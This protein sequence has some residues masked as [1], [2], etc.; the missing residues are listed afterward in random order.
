MYVC[1]FFSSIQKGGKKKTCKFLVQIP[2]SQHHKRTKMKNCFILV[3][4][5]CFIS[6]NLFAQFE[7]E[8]DFYVIFDKNFFPKPWKEGSHFHIPFFFY[9]FFFHF[10]LCIIK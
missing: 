4:W 1:N 2:E 10:V 7:T 3:E 5:K 6:E 8:N 9:V